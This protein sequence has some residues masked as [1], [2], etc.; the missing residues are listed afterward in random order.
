MSCVPFVFHCPTPVIGDQFEEGG[1][2]SAVRLKLSKIPVEGNGGEEG[3]TLADGLTDKLGL[4]EG[5]ADALG[6]T[7]T[8]GETD[9]DAD[10]VTYSG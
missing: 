7:E 1:G 6:L 8:L 10:T 4:I 2:P 3:D 9:G 5:D